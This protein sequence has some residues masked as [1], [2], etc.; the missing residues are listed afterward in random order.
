[1]AMGDIE[2][3]VRAEQE[4]CEITAA[5][6]EQAKT[7]LSKAESEGQLTFEKKI[8]EASEQAKAIIEK[9]EADAAAKNTE[10]AV[11][12]AL[13]CDE[14]RKAA[15]PQIEKAAKLICEKVMRG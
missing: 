2:K 14:I 10:H 3:I 5:A 8:A 12:A 9:A 6:A 13:R 15:K 11:S 1:M 7:I 4:A